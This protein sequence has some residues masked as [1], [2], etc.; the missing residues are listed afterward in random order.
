MTLLP[1]PVA[2]RS[3]ARVHGHWLAGIAGLNPAGGMD[4]SV[5]CKY[6]VLSGKCLCDGPI[7][8]PEESYRLWCV[9]VCDLNTSSKRRP[10]LL[11]AVAPEKHTG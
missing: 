6:C 4:K 1:I 2:G 3:K 5:S 7:P 10:C 11:W 8:R 9:I